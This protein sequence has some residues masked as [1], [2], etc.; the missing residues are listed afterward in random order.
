MLSLTG[1]TT[2]F[3]GLVI[4]ERYAIQCHNVTKKQEE[5]R[6]YSKEIG[7]DGYPVDLQ[8][9]FHNKGK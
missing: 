9:P 8:H 4:S 3:S 7:I 5:I 6:G 1:T 2:S